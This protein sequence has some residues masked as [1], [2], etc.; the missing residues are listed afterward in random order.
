MTE[1]RSG[2]YVVAADEYKKPTSD[3]FREF[4]RRHDAKE[5][6]YRELRRVV[7]EN[8]GPS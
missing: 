5:S 3:D 6:V 1:A 4:E 7:A 8:V 2:H